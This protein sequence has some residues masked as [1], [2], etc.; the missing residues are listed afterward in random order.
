[1]SPVVLELTVN[2]IIA[3]LLLGAIY[4]V[5]SIGV[6]ISFGLLDVVNVAQPALILLGSYTTLVLSVHAGI[7]PI[8]AGF[9][10]VPAFYGLGDV[11]YRIYYLSFDRHNADSILGLAFFF[12]LLFVTE[13]LLVLTF[14]V[15]YRFVRPFYVGYVLRLGIIDLPFRLVVP[16]IISLI[17]VGS[18][19]AFFTLTFIGRAVRAVA[20]DQ[21]ALRLL[22]TDPV[23]IKRIAFA[24]SIAIASPAG[25]LLIVV[26]PIEPSVARDFIGLIFAICVLGGMGSIPGT[27]LAAVAL[28]LTESLTATFIGPSWPPAVA[29]GFLLVALAVK[30]EGILRH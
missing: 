2:A 15:D 28:G 12:G 21:G 8:V 29:F 7:D 25:A 9:L 11:L 22:A 18:V 4:S 26:Q 20:Q 24:I 16:A 14:G 27:L 3:G 1:M 13:V 30:P 10:L 23:K 6:S 19:N 17:L 5:L